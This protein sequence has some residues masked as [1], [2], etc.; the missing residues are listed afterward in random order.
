MIMKKNNIRM[1]ERLFIDFIRDNDLVYEHGKFYSIDELKIVSE[2]FY[3]FVTRS[4]VVWNPY[5]HNIINDE[6]FFLNYPKEGIKRIAYAPSLGVTTFPDTAKKDL[7]DLLQRFDA[8]SIREKSG[9]DL[10]YEITGISVPVVLDPTLLLAPKYYDEITMIP[11]DI[12]KLYLDKYTL[13]LCIDQRNI[14]E[15]S[16]LI[17][18]RFFSSS[19]NKSVSYEDIETIYWNNTPKAYIELIDE[20]LSDS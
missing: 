1:M 20:L 2:S 4:D 11:D 9:S 8:L 13:A 5:L 15:D 6:G 3:A 10:I 19:L 18:E 17:I 12:P 16:S 14:I 7:R